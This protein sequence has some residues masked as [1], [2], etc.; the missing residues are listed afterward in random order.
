MA[1]NRCS[2]DI[3]DKTWRC[4]FCEAVYCNLFDQVRHVRQSHN[5]SASNSRKLSCPVNG[6]SAYFVNTSTYYKHI[7]KMHHYLYGRNLQNDFDLTLDSYTDTN[8]SNEDY[9]ELAARCDHVTD[10]ISQDE[11][12]S[13]NVLATNTSHTEQED[14]KSVAARSLMKLKGDHHLSQRALD[15]IIQMNTEITQSVC[16]R[17]K[18]TTFHILQAH[19]ISMDCYEEVQAQID[20]H[21]DIEPF[22]GIHTAHLQKKYITTNFPYIVSVC[23]YIYIYIY[24]Y[25][26]MYI[27]S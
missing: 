23:I 2:M 7:R 16:K 25:I 13:L 27:Y 9:S 22:K 17:I 6:C 1:R 8:E 5:D 11:H 20:G 3:R 24:I 10:I 19:N 26:C 12:Y 14:V 4:P 21:M 15:D 18:T